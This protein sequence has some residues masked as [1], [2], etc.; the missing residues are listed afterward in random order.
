MKLKV[1]YFASLRE[2]LGSAEELVEVPPGIASVAAL[3]GFLAAAAGV[4]RAPV[5]WLQ[6]TQ[7]GKN[8]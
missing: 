1:L 5:Q 4:R 6:S 8:R 2:A 7:R 3:R